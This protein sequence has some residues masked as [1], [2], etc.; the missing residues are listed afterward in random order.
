MMLITVLPF[1]TG[2][3]SLEKDVVPNSKPQR[4]TSLPIQPFV[5]LPTGKPQSEAQHLGCLLDQYINQKRSNP[6]GSKP[7]LKFK[8]K[9]RQYSSSHQS[10]PTESYYSIFL[11]APSSSDTCSTCTPTPECFSRKNTDNQ[12]RKTVEYQS[13][14]KKSPKQ[15]HVSPK[16]Q[17]AQVQDNTSPDSSKAETNSFVNPVSD[18]KPNLV[19]IPNYQDLINITSKQSPEPK[20]PNQF[21]SHSSY[22]S[23]CTHTPPT[24]PLTSDTHQ[25]NVQ[26]SVFPATTSQPQLN[27]PHY[28]AELAADSGLCPNSF[29]AAISTVAPLS[30]LSSLLSLAT[31]TL[32]PQQIQDSIGLSSKPSRRQQCEALM[33][34]DRPPTE[35]CLSPD[36]S[37]ESMSI[38]HLQRRGGTQ[39]RTNALYKTVLMI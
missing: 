15:N 26:A 8:E 29:T 28:R 4:P 9:T 38:S 23:T 7:G 27:F 3:C 11:E 18:P 22:P 39:L 19:R 10:S 24:L 14:S 6:S 5:L 25:P 17:M 12:S 30:C 13:T 34:S 1:L 21:M 32:H 33:Q 36:T 31:S 37:Y 20:S 16:S 35:F 2:L